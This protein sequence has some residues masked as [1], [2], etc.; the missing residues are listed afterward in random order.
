MSK[1]YYLTCAIPYANGEPHIGHAYEI[2]C[3]DVP[4]R[5]KRLDGYEVRFQTGMDEH[6]Q[7]IEQTAQKQG[8]TPQALVDRISAQ[9]RKLYDDLHISYDDLI[10]T[11]EDRHKTRAQDFW[12]AMQK[13]GDIYLGKYAGWYSVRDESYI[14]ETELTV[15]KNGAKLAPSGAPVEWM[16]EESYFFRLS[17]YQ[18]R[19]LALYESNPLFIQPNTRRNEIINFVKSGLR[20]LSIS[21]TTFKW[22]IPVPDAPGHVMYVWVDALSN[23]IT[24]LEYDSSRESGLMK[25]F[26]PA[27]IHVIGKDIIRFHAV[28]WPAFLMAAGLE[29]PNG[30]F[31]HG[32]IYN[33]GEKMSKSVG[34]VI[35]PETLVKDYGLDPVRYF[36]L[37][38]AAYGQDVDI[39]HEALVHRINGDLANDLGNLAQRSLSM[40]GKNCGAKIPTPGPFSE[41]DKWLMD[42]AQELLP[43]VRED[44]NAFTFHKAL[45]KLWGVIGDGNRYVDEQ[46]PWAL[47][48]TDAARMETVLYVLAETLRY[49]AILI[50]P[51]M[52][53]SMSKMLDQLA[54]PENQRNFSHLSPE[55][56]LKPGTTLPA[57]EGVFPRYVEPST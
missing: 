47:K 10:C 33:R 53:S 46:A 32:F 4:A 20:D 3:A 52:P 7:K 27:D 9:F 36:F 43:L 11:T 42:K 40:I 24:A 54:V 29:V 13:S 17:S 44:I 19:L 56:A 5:F 45:D 39:S 15:G 28:Y 16:E 50:Q 34:N 38:E 55:Y 23:Y 57:P 14:D 35:A 26:W 21:R 31:G 41:A 12:R 2:I 6:G 37:R 22:G 18:D 48:K 25:K 49:L 51:F 30:V 1:K 8:V